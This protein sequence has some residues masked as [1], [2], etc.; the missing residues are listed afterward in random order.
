MNM[1]SPPSIKSRVT[2]VTRVTDTTNTLNLKGFQ[3]VTQ[4]NGQLG[5]WCNKAELCNTKA[6][7]HDAVGRGNSEYGTQNHY[8]TAGA[9]GKVNG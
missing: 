4:A 5:Y 1:Q 2:D 3:H 8:P 6:S 7:I 9:R